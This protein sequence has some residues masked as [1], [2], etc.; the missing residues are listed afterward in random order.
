MK[1]KVLS[2]SAVLTILAG[3]LTAQTWSG[4]QA[5]ALQ[6]NDAKGHP[7]AEARVV[8][9]FQGVPGEM[10]PDVVATDSRGHAVLA[11]LVPGPWQVEISHP[12]YLSYIAMVDIRRDK[13]PLVSASFLEAGGRSLSPVK[14]KFSKGNRQQASP[15][16]EARQPAPP[17]AATRTAQEPSA[18]AAQMAETPAKTAA[19][20]E[21]APVIDSPA[22]PEPEPEAEP[23]PEVVATV[24]EE[25]PVPD[26][27]AAEPQVEA[28]PIGETPAPAPSAPQTPAVAAENTRVEPIP[29]PTIE[30][31]PPPVVAPAPESAPL[32]EIE[33]AVPQPASAEVESLPAPEFDEAHTPESA[34][35]IDE[36]A[37]IEPE[38][39]AAESVVTPEPQAPI[40]APRK[41]PLTEKVEPA[42][43]IPEKQ[44]VPEPET[45]IPPPQSHPAPAPAVSIE[46]EPTAVQPPAEPPMT[47]PA[48]AAAAMPPPEGPG[49]QITSHS[50]GSCSDCDSAEWTLQ[51]SV[52][53]P[54]TDRRSTGSCGV[55]VLEAARSAMQGLSTSIQ[56]E[57]DGFIGPVSD[58]TSQEAIRRVEADLA[59]AFAGELEAFIGGRSP[60]Q[61][62]GLVLPKSVRFSRVRLGASDRENAG[63]CPP[64]QSCAIGDAAWLGS[65]MMERGPSA[66]V[67]YG[68]FEN[69]ST[70]KGRRA[71]LTAYYRPPNSNWKPRLPAGN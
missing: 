31:A 38:K 24:A 57:L 46:P 4:D 68:L 10:G 7:V 70:D 45:E 42:E 28:A 11:G 56:L 21:P 52:A 59:E 2:L 65:A 37:V 71:I 32:A 58:G 49:V 41:E 69:R 16:L 22:Q 26:P 33:A 67:V 53:V 3:I 1:E 18:P 61:I 55:D 25:A 34:A 14:V 36:P 54:A 60:C 17:P 64:G 63:E 29:E 48:T 20:V 44:V 50:A 51:V 47:A 15:V 30:V 35:P 27:P 23:E 8:F 19:V 39:L 40:P 6:V 9:T 43:A 66:T 13:K 5:V 62:I 12:E